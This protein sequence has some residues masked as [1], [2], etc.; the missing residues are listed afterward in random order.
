MEGYVVRSV[1]DGESALTELRLRPY[2]MVISDLKMPKVSGLEL[3]ESISNEGI[4][5]LTVIMTGFGTVETAIEAMKKGA[6]DYVLKPFKVEEVIHIVE[7]GLD[8][9]RLHAENVRLRE[10]LTL[11]KV[12]EAMASSLEIDQVL[13]V[14]L[15]AT[16]D[17]SKGDVATLH[18]EDPPASGEYVERIKLYSEDSEPVADSALPSLEVSELLGHFRRDAPVVAHGLKANRFF[19]STNPNTPLVSYVAVPLRV[20]GRLIGMLNVFS[21]TRGKKFD[22]GARK[23]LSV[24]ASRARDRNRKR[25]PVR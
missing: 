2:D 23:L 1:D 25:T 7:R 15:R 21:F 5:V 16:L 10:A 6:Y 18:L 3:L 9:Q 12:S 13:D 4:D 11:Y 22:E 24:L 19:T 17:E 20:A 14:I 8:R